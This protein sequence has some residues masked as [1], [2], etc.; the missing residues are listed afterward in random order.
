[1]GVSTLIRGWGPK[2]FLRLA[3]EHRKKKLAPFFYALMVRG[4]VI[5]VIYIMPDDSRMLLLTIIWH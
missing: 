2:K 1:M 3:P 5:Y 4:R